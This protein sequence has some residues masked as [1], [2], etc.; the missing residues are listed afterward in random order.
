MASPNGFNAA[1]FLELITG[2][3]PDVEWQAR[4]GQLALR[5]ITASDPFS[6]SGLTGAQQTVSVVACW[7]WM[8]ALDCDFCSAPSTDWSV[9]CRRGRF[10]AGACRRGP[11]ALLRGVTSQGSRW[12]DCLQALR[13]ESGAPEMLPMVAAGELSEERCELLE[14][15]MERFAICLMREFTNT[16]CQGRGYGKVDLDKLKRAAV[17]STGGAHDAMALMEVADSCGNERN[18]KAFIDCW[19]EKEIYSCATEQ[20]NIV[21]RRS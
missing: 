12:E 10:L 9:G 6:C 5:C 2:F 13:N 11:V 16:A 15:V 21:G 14:S 7:K 19:T 17:S 3:S 18:L 4:A 1:A 8:L 20:A